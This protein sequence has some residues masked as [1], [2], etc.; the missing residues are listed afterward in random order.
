[1]EI[2]TT[3]S[4]KKAI[5][6][7]Q[8]ILK[9]IE[10][11]Q[12]HHYI[13]AVGNTGD[14]A[15]FVRKKA[16]EA[17]RIF[18]DS[19]KWAN[20]FSILERYQY[21]DFATRMTLC[22][23]IIE[24]LKGLKEHY[25]NEISLENNFS[26]LTPIKKALSIKKEEEIEIHKNINISE[27]NV[28]FLK[29]VGPYIGQKLNQVG[30]YTCDELLNYFPRE[31]ISYT[32]VTN[33]S[34]LE[35]ETDATIIA[36]VKKISSFKTQKGLIILSIILKDSSGQLKINYFF[37]GNSTHFYLKQYTSQFPLGATVIA[38]GRVKNDKYSKQKTL[39]NATLE[40]ISDDF[41]ETDRNKKAN[42]AKIVPIYPLTEGLSLKKLRSI[43]HR[44][45]ISYEN[46]IHEF[47]PSYLIEKLN[48]MDY[49]EAIRNIH[50]PQQINE[51]DCAIERLIFND[52]FL[53][54]IRFMQIRHE[55]KNKHQ[56]IEF[57]CFENG[58][59]DEF[60]ETLPFA[61]THAQKRVFF[62]EILP[63]LV[64]K[65]PMHRLLQGDV[66]SGKTIVAFLTLLIAIQDGYQAAIMAP[67][68]ILAEQ[69][70]KKFLE[71]VSKIQKDIRVGIL[72][73]KQKAK[74][75][76]NTLEKLANG[77]IDII[78]GTH[79]L[80]QKAVKFKNLGLMVIDEQHRFGV[81]QRE[82][83][84]QK[85][86]ELAENDTEQLSLMAANKK[87]QK[88]I[89]KAYGKSIEKLFMTATPIPR[90]LALALHG[91]LDM[92]EIDE[93]PSGRLPIIT[94]LCKRKSEAHDLI[95]QE[96]DKGNQAYIVFPLIEESETLS[97]KAATVEYEKI[98]ETS[99]KDYRVGLIHGRL[100]DD[101]K[102]QI[103]LAFRNKEIDILVSTT[104]IEVGVD[105]PDATVI[106]IESAERFGLAQLH[107]LRG[108]VGRNDKQSYCI[109]SS[110]SK[111][112]TTMQR[113]AILCK[114]TNGFLL[115]QEDLKIRGSG[116]ITGLKQSGIPESVLQGISNQEEILNLARQEAREL[117]KINPELNDL[118]ALKDKLKQARW[119]LNLN[120]G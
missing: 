49:K 33:I 36:T 29:G 104:V 57:N 44:T 51:K 53:M 72:I 65:E 84:A 83:L 90:T 76:R 88:D 38:I 85:A 59:V 61:L 60:L 47:L 43:I 23:K 27:L 97:A 105:V 109:L 112:M 71:W 8:N 89:D 20:I 13:N 31:H 24:T 75:K 64:S 16:R 58:L 94:T 56:G 21:L 54:Q 110:T 7:I 91:D 79:A 114:T 78:V 25:E 63:D 113:L 10:F 95:R 81:K 9:A 86:N 73:G 108:R 15:F 5:E 48:L 14:F 67:T 70:Y 100:K 1:M 4:E 3:N 119:N 37:K 22:K 103:M 19:P 34:S 92:S 2:D 120:A 18:P 77:E 28:Q 115:A 116:D 117:I 46:C 11:E 26:N 6:I 62:N 50:F 106:L 87:A 102:E 55:Y 40:V 17:L 96:I 42:I 35:E 69:H 39:T 107:Q 52:F 118:E 111:T 93:M 82:M 99:F 32:D 98:K 45:L 30:V 12:E 74:E 41:A 80:I 66:G 68:E 101:E